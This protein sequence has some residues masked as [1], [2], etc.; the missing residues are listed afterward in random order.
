MNKKILLFVTSC[1]CIVSVLSVCT[2]QFSKNSILSKAEQNNKYLLVANSSK[3]KLH[4]NNPPDK[5]SGCNFLY[6]ELGN[7][8]NFEYTDIVGSDA[9]WQE[10]SNNGSFY[11]ANSINGLE[12]VTFSFST[13]SAPFDIYWS[14]DGEFSNTKKQSFLSNSIDSETFDFNGEKPSFFKFQSNYSSSIVINSI[15]SNILA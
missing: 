8:V 3:N 1:T 10:V 5:Y 9:K 7:M 14:I 4:M 12:S 13:N 15:L 11:N 6:T 2:I